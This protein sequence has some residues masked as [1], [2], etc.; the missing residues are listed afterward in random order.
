MGDRLSEIIDSS[1]AALVGIVLICSAVIPTGL[2]FINDL[3]SS[4]VEGAS[5]YV[6]LL[7]VVITICIIAL[8]IGVL[9]TFQKDR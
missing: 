8:I 5:N 6:P 9:R 2:K 1:T 7:E 3:N 4:S